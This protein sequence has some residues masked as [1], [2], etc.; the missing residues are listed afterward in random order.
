M[1]KVLFKI[2][3]CGGMGFTSCDTYVFDELKKPEDFNPEQYQ[4]ILGQGKRKK[5]RMKVDHGTLVL[6]SEY[7]LV[8]DFDRPAMNGSVTM[9]GNACIN[10]WH[11]KGIDAARKEIEES[12]LNTG[13]TDH[14]RLLFADYSGYV[15]M[16]PEEALNSPSIRMREKAHAMLNQ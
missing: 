8:G 10:V 14:S 12:N 11:P 5:F 6:P 9:E 4:V 13:F 1:Q 3:R 2:I 7:G 15:V 16:Y